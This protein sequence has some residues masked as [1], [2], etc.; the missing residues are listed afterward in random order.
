[1]IFSKIWQRMLFFRALKFILFFLVSIYL[2]YVVI[3]LSAHSGRLFS[4]SGS[5]VSIFFYYLHHFMARLDLFLPLSL[6]LATISLLSAMN[7]HQ[8]IVSLRM[9][10]ISLGRLSLPLFILALL[11]TFSTYLNYEFALPS[12]LRFIEDFKEKNLHRHSKETPSLKVAL[13]TDGSKIVYQSYDFQKN[14]L[15]DLFWIRSHSDIWHIKYLSLQ[16]KEG[17]FADHLAREKSDLLFEKKESYDTHVF[18]EI[19]WSFDHPEMLFTPKENLS[20]T[21]LLRQNIFLSK[22]DESATSSHLYYK[23]ILPWLSPL[24]VLSL[25]PFCSRFSKNIQI[26]VVT[27]LALFAFFTFITLMDACVILGENQVVR[28]LFALALLPLFLFLLFGWRFMKTL[29]H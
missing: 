7:Q 5:L 25:I 27:T 15:F 19:S 26:F 22:S 13:L 24:V 14:E 1:M 4:S 6:L 28:P 16:S 10:G 3:D 29:K 23:L 17:R 9:A 11:L 21:A 8:E 2:I 20:I 12:S 18:S